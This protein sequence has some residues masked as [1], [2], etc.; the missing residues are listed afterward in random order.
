MAGSTSSQTHLL[1]PTRSSVLP[2]TMTGR[3]R[4]IVAFALVMCWQT[5]TEAQQQYHSAN[6]AQR[7]GAESPELLAAA[8]AAS[9]AA[10]LTAVAAIRAAL[11]AAVGAERVDV[12]NRTLLREVCA[13]PMSAACS[14]E[15]SLSL[16]RSLGHIPCARSLS[17][18]AAGSAGS[19]SF[20]EP[21]P[22]V[23]LV[24]RPPSLAPAH[25]RFALARARFPCPPL[26]HEVVSSLS[27]LLCPSTVCASTR[28]RLFPSCRA[29]PGLAERRRG[30]RGGG[31]ARALASGDARARAP[32]GRESPV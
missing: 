8:A 9:E 11:A 19:R 21:P 12:G 22:P 26:F 25:A 23:L 29:G 31:I 17:L 24:A 5:V 6:A 4:R 10:T 2:T 30:A 15:C 27:S 1:Q 20:D 32:D 16:A 3:Q 14:R 28:P 7:A 18:L 13:P